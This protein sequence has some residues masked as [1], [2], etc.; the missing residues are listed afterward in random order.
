MVECNVSQVCT[1]SGNNVDVF[2]FHSCLYVCWCDRSDI[3]VTCLYCH[4]SSTCF[5]I[6]YELDFLNLSLF[7]PVIRVCFDNQMFTDSPFLNLERTSTHD[8]CSDS[9]AGAILNYSGVTDPLL[10]HYQR[11]WF[12]HYELNSVIIDCFCMVYLRVVTVGSF[13]TSCYGINYVLSS[14]L[15][16]VM[17]LNVVS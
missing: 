4:Q 16:S 10:V 6:A 17:P 2:I 8:F 14:E 13:D 11:V 15:S 5:W 3:Q 1:R 12:L 9:I 7:T